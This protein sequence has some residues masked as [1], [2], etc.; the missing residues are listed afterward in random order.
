MGVFN[1]PLG[2]NLTKNSA[3]K[4]SPMV[5]YSYSGI[6]NP[7]PPGARG[8]LTEDGEFIL[9]ENGDFIETE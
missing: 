5:Y 2:I 9:A 8:L 3:L 1:V 4:E 6:V 7:T